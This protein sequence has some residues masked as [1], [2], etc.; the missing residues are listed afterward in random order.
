M[1]CTLSIGQLFQFSWVQMLIAMCFVLVGLTNFC[2]T[3]IQLQFHFYSNHH[4]RFHCSPSYFR[5]TVP[6]TRLQAS[7]VSYAFSNFRQLP[8]AIQ[9]PKPHLLEGRSTKWSSEI[10]GHEFWTIEDDLCSW[11]CGKLDVYW[12]TTWRFYGQDHCV[13]ILSVPGKSV[14]KI[15]KKPTVI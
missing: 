9:C 14:G 5:K 7:S 4:P 11:P 15:S 6:S 12:E 10:C 13:C 3:L 1:S 2:R 8:I